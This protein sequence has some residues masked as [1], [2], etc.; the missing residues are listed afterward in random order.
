M[1]QLDFLV[2]EAAAVPTPASMFRSPRSCCRG[3]S[4]IRTEIGNVAVFREFELVR[5]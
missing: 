5:K 3:S 1:P 2:L 4:V